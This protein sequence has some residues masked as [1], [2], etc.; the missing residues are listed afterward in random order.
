VT[1]GGGAP[2]PVS[3]L[4]AE[5]YYPPYLFKQDGSGEPATRPEILSAPSQ[6]LGWSEPFSVEVSP[7]TAIAQVRLIR[8]GSVTHAF[9][10]EQRA[11]T[12]PFAQVGGM[13]QMQM[14]AERAVAPPGYYLLFVVAADGVPSVARIIKLNAAS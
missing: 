6:Q 1:G 10:N 7:D 14:P 8:T 12:L 3:N 2:G 9:N 11:M 4:N 5:I 13:L